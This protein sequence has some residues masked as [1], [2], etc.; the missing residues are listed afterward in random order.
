MTKYEELKIFI[1]D[2]QEGVGKLPWAEVEEERARMEK[3][4][5][6]A[7]ANHQISGAQ[8]GRLMKLLPRHVTTASSTSPLLP[9]CS[10]SPAASSGANA[11]V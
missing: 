3:E 2:L 1:A 9:E 11:L 6:E 8:A 10:H 4:I 5:R 7:H